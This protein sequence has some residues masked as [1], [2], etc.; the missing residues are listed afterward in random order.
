MIFDR[1]FVVIA[2]LRIG[3]LLS[4]LW[5]LD[6]S[7]PPFCFCSVVLNRDSVWFQWRRELKMTVSVV[8]D[9]KMILEFGREVQR[10]E[11]LLRML[12]EFGVC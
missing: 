8:E 3:T 5:F 7:S 2:P 6:S 11:R 10:F 9:W 1:D 4:F 12:V